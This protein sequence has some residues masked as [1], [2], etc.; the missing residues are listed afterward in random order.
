MRISAKSR[1]AL[2]SMIYMCQNY[3]DEECCTISTLSEELGI[4]K[5]YLE[6]VFSALK[7]AKL[8]IS[9]KGAQGGYYIS[10]SPEKIK[11][12]DIFAS[13]ENSLF[14]KAEKTVE[15]KAEGIERTM[16]NF[17]FDKMDTAINDV[18]SCISLYDLAIQANEDYIYYI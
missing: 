1:Y 6:Q 17:V 13:I 18:L 9:V 3:K 8:V 5:I 2:A 15:K 11:I 7:H 12:R 14:E 16:Q 4:S 10:K